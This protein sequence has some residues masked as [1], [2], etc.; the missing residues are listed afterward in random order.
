MRT[1]THKQLFREGECRSMWSAATEFGEITCA[2]V[3]GRTVLIHD[4]VD[5]R[6]GFEVY[7]QTRG[8]SIDSAREQLGLQERCP[9][10]S[11][12]GQRCMKLAGHLI[13]HQWT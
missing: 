5:E 1:K 11:G 2:I 12:N 3:S 9:V 6:D 7:T 13:A 8:L 10:Q 4:Y